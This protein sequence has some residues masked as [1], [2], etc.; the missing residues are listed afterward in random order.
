MMSEADTT[1]AYRLVEESGRLC[2]VENSNPQAPGIAVEM[3]AFLLRPRDR[4]ELGAQPL[5][6]AA[7]KHVVTIFDATAGLGQDS[8]LL[9]TCGYQVTASER[10]P[11]IAALLEDGFARIQADPNMD[12]K[13]RNNLRFLAGDA[14]RLLP[15]QNPR[16]DAVYLDP[17]YPE[18]KKTALPKKELQML[19]KVV[20]PDDDAEQLFD[21]AMQCATQRVIVKRPHYAPPLKPSPSMS[22]QGKLVRFD[23]YLVRS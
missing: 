2:L 13:V 19:R 21:V 15:Q 1:V 5:I 12:E 11:L 17:M 14:I 6:K 23:V 18:K 22:Y 7:G 4:S 3:P 16:P 10:E 8:L 20:G 9:A